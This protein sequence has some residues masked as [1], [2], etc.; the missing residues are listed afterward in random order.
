MVY[1]NL[2]WLGLF[3]LLS[4]FTYVISKIIKN[5]LF[6]RPSGFALSHIQIEV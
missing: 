3:E 4:L 1:S 6:I 5:T 2:F